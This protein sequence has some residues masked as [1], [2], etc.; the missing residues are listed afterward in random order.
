[1]KRA[2]MIASTLL[3]ICC[4][5]KESSSVKNPFEQEE[6]KDRYELLKTDAKIEENLPEVISYFK[7][8]KDSGPSSIE[9]QT[10]QGMLKLL[11]ELSVIVPK[12]I[13]AKADS[14]VAD[15][16]ARQ[17]QIFK[18]FDAILANEHTKEMETRYRIDEYKAELIRIDL[19]ANQKVLALLTR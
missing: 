13:A 8:K 19:E 7:E 1:M 5:R 16:I 2:F 14:S 15:L 18:S 11:E 10:H 12:I 4:S 6:R 17:R 9:A 3:L